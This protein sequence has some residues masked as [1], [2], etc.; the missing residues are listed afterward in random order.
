V[1]EITDLLDRTTPRPPAFDVAALVKRGRHRR[2]RAQVGTGVAGVALVATALAGLGR[3]SPEDQ[4]QVVVVNRPPI[5]EVAE[6][7]A[8][9]EGPLG[10]W[11]EVTD[12]PFS[13]RMGAFTGT[14]SQGRVVVW[15][16][17]P[18]A[19]GGGTEGGGTL[20]DGG[21]YHVEAAS[22]E[23]IPPAPVPAGVSFHWTQLNQDRLMVLGTPDGSRLA[24]AVYDLASRTWSEI[25]PPPTI[26]LPAEGVAWTGEVLALARF[27]SGAEV[28]T[29]RVATF[30][31]PVVERWSLATGEWETGAEPPLSNRFGPAVSFDGER[32]G[33]WGGVTQEVEVGGLASAAEQVG[34]G[35]VYDV[36]ADRWEAIPLGA[37][38]PVMQAT[39][40]WLESGRLAVAGG[41]AED[42]SGT[43]SIQSGITGMH[44]DHV[45]T[46]ALYDPETQTWTLL[47][48][49]PGTPFET[50]L[51]V[52]YRVI[53][54]PE[55]PFLAID[56]RESGPHP[57]Y[58]YDEVTGAW[59]EVP[60]RDL[61]AIGGT[62]IA[63]SRTTDNPGDEPFEVEVLAGSMWEPATVAPFTNRMDA[64]VAVFDQDLFVVGG[65]EG[66]DL[67]V[68]G[69]AWVLHFETG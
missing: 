9:A 51:G 20:T 63:T 25:Q 55:R 50:E 21:V 39:A 19:E 54:R 67:D 38:S 48:D 6:A 10:T 8:A 59:V 61:Q 66:S 7:F 12:P 28:D 18:S 4:G 64:G 23:A 56:P 46:A 45:N 30:A 36:T 13:P 14:A 62:L 60:L 42:L 53:D 5:G 49:A 2:R 33:V 1:P 11:E 15:G 31:E 29:D 34:D 37:L 22:W 3:V 27:W 44:L 65:A 17:T 58:L 32:L 16:G 41:V 52:P 43:S 24:G 40:L 35:A 69:D 68:Q 26:T 57:M 47:P